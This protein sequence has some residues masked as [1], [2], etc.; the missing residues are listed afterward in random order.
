IIEAV[1]RREEDSKRARAVIER[2][3]NICS[4]LGLVL[5]TYYGHGLAD[6]EKFKVRVGSPVRPMLAERLP[7]A[8]K[9]IQKISRCEVEAKLDGFH[10]RRAGGRDPRHRRARKANPADELSEARA[11]RILTQLGQESHGD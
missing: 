9:I 4:D 2:A 3:Y 7:S 11:G 5:A 6:L 10:G 1:A 8:E